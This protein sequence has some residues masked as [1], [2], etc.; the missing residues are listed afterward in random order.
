ML[1]KLFWTTGFAEE[2]NLNSTVIVTP[3][4]QEGLGYIMHIIKNVL[5]LF[6]LL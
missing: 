5:L 3:L 2:K 1:I 4:R 6:Y